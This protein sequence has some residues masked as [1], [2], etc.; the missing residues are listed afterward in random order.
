MKGTALVL[1]SPDT[2]LLLPPFTHPSCR[3]MTCPSRCFLKLHCG[4]NQCLREPCGILEG[5]DMVEI[6]TV[7]QNMGRRTWSHAW[8]HFRQTHGTGCSVPK[9]RLGSRAFG[10]PAPGSTTWFPKLCTWRLPTHP[11]EFSPYVTFYCNFPWPFLAEWPRTFSKCTSL[12]VPLDQKL[13]P[14]CPWFIAESCR[15]R[16]TGLALKN[17]DWILLFF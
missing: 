5:Q 15:S 6:N 1:P 12:C 8:W 17:A 7:G 13:R 9:P 14:P 2:Q 3:E 4:R 11:P 16:S 10:Y